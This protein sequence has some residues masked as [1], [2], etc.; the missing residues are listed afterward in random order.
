MDGRMEGEPSKGYEMRE[1]G[2]TSERKMREGDNRKELGER[3][4]GVSSLPVAGG[5][6]APV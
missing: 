6:M 5:V 2:Q 4:K 3:E 1:R